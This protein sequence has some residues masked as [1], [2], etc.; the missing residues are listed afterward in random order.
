MR[1]I[2]LYR[3]II[4]NSDNTLYIW[5]T[6]IAEYL[7][8]LA[9]YIVRTIP[10]NNYRINNGTLRLDKFENDNEITYVVEID[11]DDD[12]YIRCYQVR[13]ITDQSD[14]II[15][16]LSLDIFGTYLHRFAYSVFHVTRC[17]KNVNGI[18]FD[19]FSTKDINE[20]L[21]PLYAPYISAYNL[22]NLSNYGLLIYISLK[23]FS[24]LQGNE[25]TE[26]VRPYYIRLDTIAE[27][28]DPYN[29][30][31]DIVSIATEIACNISKVVATGF[32]DL[33]A[34]PV[35]AY[36]VRD[37]WIRQADTS[38]IFITRTR[39]GNYAE[40]QWTLARV[41]PS[42]TKQSIAVDT[43]DPRKKYYVGTYNNAM[44]INAYASN[45]Q[46][47]ISVAVNMANFSLFVI[48]GDNM[49]ELTND[50]KVMMTGNSIGQST[51]EKMG[52]YMKLIGDGINSAIS[53]V[54]TPT[55]SNV[56]SQGVSLLS[57]AL[58]Q[59]SHPS[60]MV[61][62]GSAFTTYTYRFYDSHMGGGGNLHYIRVP[63][64][65]IA[66]SYDNNAKV[67]ATYYGGE[68]NEI[69]YSINSLFS[70]GYIGNTATFMF[71]Q[72][73]FVN[74]QNVPQFV[75][76]YFNSVFMKGVRLTQ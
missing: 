38:M 48:Q 4:P 30:N 9:T 14:N 46:V 1:S 64:Y 76:D 67:Y 27:T 36:I 70:L 45:N 3:S 71:L 10:I 33:E 59:V 12:T 74:I 42:S 72:G 69:L 61:G 57:N 25:Y 21:T 40:E 22:D 56:I 55:P 49:K 17:S 5:H 65:L 29:L 53:V 20:T 62:D 63:L 31:I 73:E 11:T 54:S 6:T 39:F 2:R 58:P 16:T 51:S 68:C 23:E 28:Y 52:N 66:Y 15:Y 44:P 60:G 24:T 37:E 47:C 32:G 41:I 8:Y 43:S 75:A 35:F 7:D 13:G 34:K 18:K 19:T 50:L 26:N